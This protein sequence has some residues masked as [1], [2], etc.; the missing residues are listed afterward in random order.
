MVAAANTAGQLS[1]F[2]IPKP[3][4]P[5]LVRFTRTGGSLN[6]GREAEF[7]TIPGAHSSPVTSL[8]WAVNGMKLFS[9]DQNGEVRQVLL[10]KKGGST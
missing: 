10:T 9:G 5:T 7:F 2:Q 6:D 4:D 1:I 3:L 8:E